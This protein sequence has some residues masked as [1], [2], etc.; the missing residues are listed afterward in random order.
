MF[1]SNLHFGALLGSGNIRLQ[2]FPYFGT[3]NMR[4]HSHM[5]LTLHLDTLHC[6]STFFASVARVAMPKRRWED[7]EGDWKAG[8]HAGC[9]S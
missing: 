4:P 1:T 6:S 2:M 5:L 7:N 8:S 3:G 9:E